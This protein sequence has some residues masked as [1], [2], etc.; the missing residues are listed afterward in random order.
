MVSESLDTSRI[1]I[2]LIVFLGCSDIP[3][4]FL[5]PLGRKLPNQVSKEFFDQ[6]QVQD[7]S[8][9]TQFLRR[10]E[11][12]H[13]LSQTLNNRTATNPHGGQ[14]AHDSPSSEDEDS[15]ASTDGEESVDMGNSDPYAIGIQPEQFARLSPATAFQRTESNFHLDSQSRY[16]VL[17]VRYF[18][19][20]G[21][22]QAVVANYPF[23]WMVDKSISDSEDVEA[24][25]KKT[26]EMLAEAFLERQKRGNIHQR[27]PSLLTVP[28][29]GAIPARNKHHWHG[30]KEERENFMD[31]AAD[32]N[33]LNPVST[34]R[35]EMMRENIS[36][37]S[38]QDKQ[39]SDNINDVWSTDVI[40]VP[41]LTAYFEVTIH[42]LPQGTPGSGRDT[43]VA[44]GL[45]RKQFCL[46]GLM[47]GWDKY[48][49]AWHGDDGN[50]F[51]NAGAGR[52]FGPSFGVGDTVGC[53]IDYSKCLPTK[54]GSTQQPDEARIFFTLNGQYVGNAFG[55]VDVTN[56][57]WPVIGLDSPCP[58]SFNF[59]VMKGSEEWANWCFKIASTSY[60]S[61]LTNV[62]L[63]SQFSQTQKTSNVIVSRPFKFDIRAYEMILWN[64][65]MSSRQSLTMQALQRAPSSLSSALDTM[66]AY[67]SVSVEEAIYGKF[68][69]NDVATASVLHSLYT[70]L[71]ERKKSKLEQKA[72]ER[73][74]ISFHKKASQ[75]ISKRPSNGIS[76]DKY[77]GKNFKERKLE[78]GLCKPSDAN[79]P[80]SRLWSSASSAARMAAR[81]AATNMVNML[82]FLV[83]TVEQESS[84]LLVEAA[85]YG[86]SSSDDRRTMGDIP[87]STYPHCNG[88]QPNSSASSSSKRKPK[89]REVPSSLA[90]DIFR[91]PQWRLVQRRSL[92]TFNR[93]WWLPPEEPAEFA[94]FVF[95]DRLTGDIPVPVL[96][97]N[98]REYRYEANPEEA[99]P[100]TENSDVHSTNDEASNG[101]ILYAMG[102]Y[103]SDATRRIDER[104]DNM[105][106]DSAT[107]ARFQLIPDAFMNVSGTYRYWERRPARTDPGRSY[108]DNDTALSDEE[109]ADTEDT[110]F[111]P[112]AMSASTRESRQ[113]RIFSSRQPNEDTMLLADS[114]GSPIPSFGFDDDDPNEP[115][116]NL[117]G[118]AVS[119][120]SDDDANDI[121]QESPLSTNRS[122]NATASRRFARRQNRP[123]SR[124]RG[125]ARAAA[126]DH[127]ARNT[128]A[129]YVGQLLTGDDVTRDQRGGF[130][131]V[132]EMDYANIDGNNGDITQVSEGSSLARR[133]NSMPNELGLFHLLEQD[134]EDQED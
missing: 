55:C 119:I 116:W 57:L 130:L 52:A 44:V 75:R 40:V 6:I 78:C 1:H 7:I 95:D 86:Q 17:C 68:T 25:R 22:N 19:N 66:E 39:T 30:C 38:S 16:P 94:E 53:G 45:A 72:Y 122:S 111:A 4:R 74:R 105:Q 54:W 97:R 129:E 33:C 23:P 71:F 46:A 9:Y 14:N 3:L 31:V 102:R 134:Q 120:V 108:R 125:A 67:P 113:P 92:P 90:D 37:N 56:P 64:H 103:F 63:P 80:L 62:S 117:R 36:S 112:S 51:H 85:D 83:D 123:S 8:N 106:P 59:G 41:R 98:T 65:V 91:M 26:T 27:H 58:V 96:H 60:S 24:T 5:T 124:G 34:R 109:F 121:G 15:E 18:G 118:E 126:L 127:F 49:F 81:E 114:F 79:T 110:P 50:R 128:A 107:G 82:D 131:G 76:E 101:N 28:Y 133:Q 77:D 47:P 11:Q 89:E 104:T 88:T 32:T 100:G 115:I 73:L 43:C 29:V 2:I 132:E 87:R 13:P 20:E 48:S 10:P 93:L 35:L 70:S 84:K 69:M 99:G 42:P 61:D 21:G 12:T